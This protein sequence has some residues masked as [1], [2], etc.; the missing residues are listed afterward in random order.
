MREL[1]VNEI[2]E[3][4]GASDIQGFGVSLIPGP[5]GAAPRLL[6]L[7]RAE[8]PTPTPSDPGYRLLPIDPVTV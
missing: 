6:P 7:T 8:P 3:V 2:L 4:S 1:D 5:D